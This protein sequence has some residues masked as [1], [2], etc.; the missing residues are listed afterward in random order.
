MYNGLNIF[1]S[2]IIRFFGLGLFIK[3]YLPSY[4]EEKIIK[5]FN[6]E[7]FKLIREIVKRVGQNRVDSIKLIRNPSG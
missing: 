6:E 7:E 4:M 3:S 5:G 1:N 2:Y